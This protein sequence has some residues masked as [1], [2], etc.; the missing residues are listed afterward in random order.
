LSV[1]E[2][3]P[4]VEVRVLPPI[5]RTMRLMGTLLFGCPKGAP[6]PTGFDFAIKPFMA[7]AG[8][9]PSVEREL[10]LGYEL[11]PAILGPAF[12]TGICRHRRIWT[13]AERGQTGRRNASRGERCEHCGRAGF[14]EFNVRLDAAYAVGVS[15]HPDA[16]GRRGLQ[17]FRQFVERGLGFRL[18]S[19]PI[20]RF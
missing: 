14:R 17:K 12:F 8:A 2:M 7:E 15:H 9:E 6:P 20:I 16:E 18:E 4:M 3:D 5:A 19:V 1:G 11:D 10:W 13:V